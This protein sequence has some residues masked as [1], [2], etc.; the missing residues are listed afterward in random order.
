MDHRELKDSSPWNPLVNSAVDLKHLGKLGEEINELGCAVSRCIIQG[1]DA[2][3]PVTGKYNQ[4]WLEEEIAD[5]KAN[6]QLV[7][8]HFKLKRLDDRVTRKLEH[9]RQWHNMAGQ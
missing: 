1:V 8:E 3:E 5:V 7:E 6:I 4:D 9:L 2:Y